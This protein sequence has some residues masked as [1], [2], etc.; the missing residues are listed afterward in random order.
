MRTTFLELAYGP[1]FEAGLAARAHTWE[2][3]RRWGARAGGRW[4]ATLATLERTLTV[5]GPG[6]PLATIPADALTQVTVLATHRRQ[7]LLTAMLSDSLRAAKDRGDAVSV[8]MAAE[9]TIYGR[10][11]YAPAELTV[12]SRLRTRRAGSTPPPATD[13]GTLRQVDTEEFGQLAP[14][15]FHAAMGLRAGNINRP[16]KW[17]DRMVGLNGLSLDGPRPHYI[18]REGPTGPD[19]FVAWRPK[20]DHNSPDDD[21][22]IIVDDMVAASP[23]A[24][25][26]LWNYL[27]TMDLVDEV[28]LE[29]R[30]IDEPIRWLL[31]DPRTLHVRANDGIWLRILDLPAALSAR[32]YACTDSLVLDVVDVDTGGYAQ[33]RFALDGGPTHAHCEPAPGRSADLTVSQR[34]LAS[35]YL[36]GFTLRQ[37]LLG[38]GIV[39]HTPGTLDRLD[40]MLA[41]ALAPWCYTD[42]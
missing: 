7:G 25:Q 16:S 31:P 10:F 19:G 28:T 42:F 6:Y 18:V 8:L 12:A 29:Q 9:A 27:A 21:G 20:R 17:W 23:G 39:E 32:R 41:T 37:Q 5:P 36:G 38:G 15:I 4:V 13:G 11:G 34:A 35:A 24:Y 2:P 30:P 26:A 22:A 14:P 1:E 33:G 3:D 40:A